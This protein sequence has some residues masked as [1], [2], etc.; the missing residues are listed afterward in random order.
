MLSYNFQLQQ[1]FLLHADPA[2]AA[3]ASAYMLN[4]FEFYGIPMPERRKICHAFIKTNPLASINGV[5]KVVKEAW[6]LPEREWQY[7]A[8]ELLMHYKKQWRISTRRLI[9]YC[10]MHKSWWDTVDWIADA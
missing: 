5:E 3:G 6:K 9:E 1:Q 2:R 4:Q 8:I 10:I 7:F